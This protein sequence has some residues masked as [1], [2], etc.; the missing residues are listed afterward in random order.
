MIHLFMAVLMSLVVVVVGA[1]SD[2]AAVVDTESDGDRELQTNTIINAACNF[3]SRILPGNVICDCAITVGFIFV[4]AFQDQFCL[5]PE[6]TGY[7]SIPTLQGDIRLLRRT[8]AFE[9]CLNDA[10]NGGVAAPGLCFDIGGELDDEDTNS[11][12]ISEKTEV[13]TTTKAVANVSSKFSMLLKS[14]IPSSPPQPSRLL[15]CVGM[16][17]DEERI[18]CN[19]CQLCDNN[20]GYIFDC[21]NINELFI[22]ST[23]T[24]LS[25]L[26]NLRDPNQDI[27]FFPQFDAFK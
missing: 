4:C 9:F 18:Q 2:L 23:C 24:P 15:D 20:T 1:S 25:I 19:S 5:G 17:D 12:R 22:Q 14:L 7:C 21:T 26:T 16:S 27:K 13:S 10:T 3:V 11:F 6:S 8:I